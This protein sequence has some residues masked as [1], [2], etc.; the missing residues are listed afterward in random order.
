[1][2]FDFKKIE[3][4]WKINWENKR[5]YDFVNNA[6]NQNYYV[7]SMF[8][9]PSGEGLHVGHPKSYT[10]TDIIA[11]FKKLNG[12][13][14]LHPIGWDAFGL[15]AE[16]Y[17]I[18][19]N[20]SPKEF[21]KKNID[22]F[23]KQLKNLGFYFNYDKEVNTTDPSYYKWTQ[24]IFLKL[25]ENNLA[26]IQEVEVNWCPKLGTVL[27]NEEIVIENNKMYSERDHHLVYKKPMRQWV[28]KITHYAEKLLAGLDTLD[29]PESLKQAQRNWIGKKQGYEVIFKNDS[30]SLNVFADNLNL[31]D[32]KSAIYLP[33]DHDFQK[34]FSNDEKFI[35]HKKIIEQLSNFEKENLSD[36][37][38]IFKT[39]I[40]LK[41]E[42]LNFEKP[43]FF[44]SSL[45]SNSP[46]ILK[47]TG[48]I[49]E[50]TNHD[51]TFSMKI[52]N[53]IKT[54]VIKPKTVYKL[55]DWVFSRQRYWGEPFPVYFENNEIKSFSEEQLPV[56]L[57]ELNNFKPSENL[58]PPLAKLK[59]WVNFKE[60]CFR[61]TNTMPQWAGSCWY[62]IAYLL[63]VP[64][65]DSYLALN[66]LQAKKI[67][68]EWLPVNL[69]IGGKEHA[70]LHFLYARFWHMVL[71][72]IGIVSSKEPFQ[73]VI[74]QGMILGENNEKMSKSKGNV[75]NPD[76]V[77][78]KYGA[79]SLRLYMMFMGPLEM[80]FPWD[81]KGIVAMQKWLQRVHQLFTDKTFDNENNEHLKSEFNILLESANKHLNSFKF[82]LVISSMMV[83]INFCYKQKS[84]NAE[85]M[86]NFL[87]ILSLYAPFIAEELFSRYSKTVILQNNWPV[88]YEINLAKK[89]EI[90]IVVQ[91]N[92]KLKKIVVLEKQL[93]EKDFLA[94]LKNDKALTF[95]FNNVNIK[96]KY[97]SNK[98]INFII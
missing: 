75:V 61:E 16:Q 15:P 30:Y 36:N 9:Y 43:L 86:K 56:L 26:E 76:E 71:H 77:I 98:L 5:V 48:N 97:I 73:K 67:L 96:Y 10:A 78:E 18:K 29:W 42:V 85:V 90:K 1:M 87:I 65:S 37:H 6:S 27:A 17:A 82:N 89:T 80:S 46:A 68:D 83:F 81:E 45:P 57:P 54:K 60:N 24:W 62:Y 51:K 25:F 49:K 58:E 19:T 88:S 79:D 21:T 84:L 4:K 7:L 41:D 93:S 35:E 94:F 91:I 31:L 70:T 95:I 52:E 28:L 38:L 72:D 64:H 47:F 11:R 14:V 55:K 33:Y 8:P 23:R 63:K 2:A 50:K 59:E 40:L 74:N 39:N 44:D 12:F 92:G 66:S 13:N 69:Y 3:E 53:A 32:E 20:N 22:N 34:H